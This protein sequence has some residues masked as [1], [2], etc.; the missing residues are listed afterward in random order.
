MYGMVV[1][2]FNQNKAYQ[3]LANEVAYSSFDEF[4]NISSQFDSENNMPETDVPVNTRNAKTEKRGTNGVHPATEGYYQIADV[5]Y[6]N[7]VA[8]FCQ[9]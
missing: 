8:N 3:E 7:F 6:R 5:V 1:A 4:V 9:Y 2:A